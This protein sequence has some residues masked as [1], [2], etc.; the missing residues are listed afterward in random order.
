MPSTKRHGDLFKELLDSL[1]DLPATDNYSAKDRYVDFRK[2]FTGSEQGQR[3][4]RELLAWG[5]IFNVGIHGTPIDP[6][7]MMIAEGH[8]N[9]A[10]KLMAAVNIEPPEQ[11]KQTTSR[12]TISNPI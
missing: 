10:T 7:K 8:R 9:F 11:P 12:R 4:Y 3:V 5:K 6:Y 1:N 2:L